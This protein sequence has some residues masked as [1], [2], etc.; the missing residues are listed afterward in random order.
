MEVVGL[1]LGRAPEPSDGMEL[2]FCQRP[3]LAALGTMS[4]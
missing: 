1:S 4:G 3:I 2:H